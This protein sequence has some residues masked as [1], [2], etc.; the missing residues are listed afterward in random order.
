MSVMSVATPPTVHWHT[1]M[2]ATGGAGP[3]FPIGTGLSIPTTVPRMA[4]TGGMIPGNMGASSSSSDGT[5]SGPGAR[6]PPVGGT[7]REDRYT[8][9]LLGLLETRAIWRGTSEIWRRHPDSNRGIRVL[10]TLALPL[11]YAASMSCGAASNSAPADENPA[12][13]GR[14]DPRLARR[15]SLAQRTPI[16]QSAARSDGAWYRRVANSRGDRIDPLG[17]E[18][19]RPI[20]DSGRPRCRRHGRGVSRA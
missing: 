18:S 1:S 12:A 16:P 10:Q 6:T 14:E 11:G 2:T 15:T 9:P 19:P 3:F 4:M 5:V 7:G 8:P 17:R 13:K 20:R